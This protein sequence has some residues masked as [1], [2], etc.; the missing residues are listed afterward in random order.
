MSSELEESFSK[1]IA[2]IPVGGVGKRL[3]PLT[4]GHSKPLVR[5]CCRPMIDTI[6]AELAR[7]VGIDR[8]IFGVQGLQNYQEL[9]NYFKSGKGYSIE[10]ALPRVYIHYQPNIEDV[11]SADSLRINMEYYSDIF[12]SKSPIIV[13]QGDNLFNASDVK[14]ILRFHKEKNA[15]LSIALTPVENVEEFGV[16]DIDKETYKI[17]RF[18]EKPKKEEA[19]SNLINTGIYVFSPGVKEVFY[20]ETIQEKI[21]KGSLDF[22]YDLIPYIVENYDVY[23]YLLKH[24]WF[25]VGN[26]VRY[27]QAMEWLLHRGKPFLTNFYEKIPEEEQIFVGGISRKSTHIKKVI[28]KKYEQEKIKCIPPVIF[29]KHCS[30]GENIF[31][32]KSTIDNYTNIGNNVIID[33]SAIMDFCIIGDNAEIGHSIIDTGCIIRSNQENPTK[34]RHSTIG[35]GAKI[36]PGCEII[37]SKI[38]PEKVVRKGKY[39]DEDPYR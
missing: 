31:I 11:G 24:R 3:R 22:G 15:F 17:K 7:E 19:P 18:I 26:P 4:I 39:I 32:K 2:F 5:M 30:V 21:N 6:I 38:E 37:G 27:L 8:F 28:S 33:S 34:I 35:R 13:V 1:P 10:Y 36:E 23:G 12:D 25:D 20:E 9:W 16:A 29:G 14:G